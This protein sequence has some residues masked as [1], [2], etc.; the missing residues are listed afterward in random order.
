[1]AIFFIPLFGP[2]TSSYFRQEAGKIE[3]IDVRH[4]T[5]ES[6][7][8]E[9]VRRELE[10]AKTALAIEKS[11]KCRISLEKAQVEANFEDFREKVAAI[12]VNF[13]FVMLEKIL[14]T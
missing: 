14:F 5:D 9:S 4:S 1:M 2:T 6:C 7:E 11:E 10:D 13:T 3:V 8:L 12:Q